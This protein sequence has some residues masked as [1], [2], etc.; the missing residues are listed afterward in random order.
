[1]N[2]FL[3]RFTLSHPGVSTPII[4]TKNLKHLAANNRAASKGAL[5]A[6]VYAEA[7]RRLDAV[8]VVAG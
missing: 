2:D 6:D 4:G 1:M 8:G 5:R 7:K 3:I